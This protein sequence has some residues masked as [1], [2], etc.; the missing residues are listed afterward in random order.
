MRRIALLSLCA[1]AALLVACGGSQQ[2]ASQQ[3]NAANM[4]FS[5][6]KEAQDYLA[7][8]YTEDQMKKMYI[9]FAA[10]TVADNDYY[11]KKDESGRYIENDEATDNQIFKKMNDNITAVIKRFGINHA[12]YA[13]LM[14][15]VRDTDWP[16]TLDDQV[17]AR[18]KEINAARSGGN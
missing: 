9:E 5:G 6:I 2:S 8:H 15:H 4:T 7:S 12:L 10:L 11:Y 14:L 18:A 13:A 16:M 17:S 3:D 1:V